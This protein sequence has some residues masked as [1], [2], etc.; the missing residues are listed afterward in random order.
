VGEPVFL[1]GSASE[2]GAQIGNWQRAA[3]R[4][5]VARTFI[6][7]ETLNGTDELKRRVER[8]A[9]VL[10]STTPHWLEEATAQA[11]SAE[12]ETWQLLAL[13]CL[14]PKFW[15]R[16]YIAPSIDGAPLRS[17]FLNAAEAQGHEHLLGSGECTAFFILGQSTLSGDVLFHK[18]REVRDET[19]FAF[20]RKCPAKFRFIGGADVGN[21]GTAHCL[22]EN[23]WAGAN[24]TGSS[25]ISSEYS[26]CALS[27]A[28]ALRYF[29]E[30][31]KTLDDIVPACESLI[32][33]NWLGGGGFEKGSIFMFAD[34]ERGLVIEATSK[35][36]AH[37]WF[38]GDAIQARTNHF[39]LPELLEYSKEPHP[40]SVLR[41]ERTQELLEIGGGT[42]GLSLCGEIARDRENAPHAICRDPQDRLGSIT[43]SASSCV[44][45][46]YCEMHLRNGHPCFVPVVILSPFDRVCDSD[47]LCGAH[48]ALSR[49]LRGA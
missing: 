15:G 43:V 35:R 33:N 23:E 14:P 37:R 7:A 38:D 11:D 9:R 30:N 26:D 44:L 10:E 46:N 47:L 13:N 49:K 1:D 4:E 27:D 19:Q 16:D 34:K 12:I 48:N 36:M 39:V 6:R 2:I 42:A 25:L 24:N 45:G 32:A 29:A 22:T 17:D 3:L 8:F 18:N 5:R 20:T 41:L 28:H 21:L 40:G 31:C